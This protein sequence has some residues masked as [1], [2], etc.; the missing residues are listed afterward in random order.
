MRPPTESVQTS[1]APP[2]QHTRSSRAIVLLNLDGHIVS[3]NGHAIKALG[4]EEASF[5]GKP[6][7]D[8]FERPSGERM[9]QHYDRALK[10]TAVRCQARLKKQGVHPGPLLQIRIRLHVVGPNCSLEATW[11]THE[12]GWEPSPSAHEP[13]QAAFETL[14]QAYLELQGIN[15]QKTQ[16]LAAA[17]HELKTPLA[18]INGS[19]ELLLSGSLG[20]LNPQ[21]RELVQLSHHNCRRLENVVNS[22]LDYSAVERG[23]L[24]LVFQEHDP[25][26]MI[27]DTAR[28]WRRVGQTRGVQFDHAAAAQLPR[29]K[30]DR[31]KV[32]NVLNGLCE[33]ALKYTPKGGQVTLI[34]DLHFWERRLATVNVPTERRG[35]E[36]A[37]P[38]GI[39]FTVS[40][41]GPGIPSEYHQEIFEEY[42]QVPGITGGGM[43]LGLSIARKIVNAHKGK[44][45][46]ESRLGQGT[47][48][49]FVIPL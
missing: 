13:R 39:R 36:A 2:V 24:S 23:K 10:G 34:A 4:V 22:F 43:G 47:A 40:D 9:K 30:C 14:F 26:D 25:A 49:H 48:F 18:V 12:P 5:L 15:K 17:T 11:E 29:L 3:A 32:Q 8:L 35:E 19:C 27:A 7:S 33:N 21:Q 1:P 38:N 46:V 45:W 16:M 44:I 41:N 6:L 42:F 28:Y 37:V 31:A 20:A